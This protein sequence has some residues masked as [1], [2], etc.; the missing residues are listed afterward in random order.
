MD[1]WELEFK[2]SPKKPG[3]E[4]LITNLASLGFESF[5]ENN[6]SLMAYIT[7]ELF[8]KNNIEKEIEK[9]SFEGVTFSYEKN[10]IPSQNWNAEWEKDFDP[11]FVNDKL[12]I[13]APFH[14]LNKRFDYEVVIQPQMSFGTGH[15][16]T[17]RQLAS[18]LLELEL[19]NKNVLDVGTGTGVLAILAE[20]LGAKKI[21]GT[22]IDDGSYE[23][24]K[25]NV[26]LNGA[27]NIKLLKGDIDIV[28]EREF[29]VILANIN[30][31]VLI[32]HLPVYANLC[33][34]NGDLIMSGFFL[35]DVEELEKEALINGF[36]LEKTFNSDGWAVAYFTKNK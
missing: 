33:K 1:Y 8:I 24:A 25:S 20:K 9:L 18:F 27:E 28:T 7:S 3:E 31:N 15:H 17:T 16:D 11:V 21:I 34:L 10:L 6:D 36:H 26:E 2:V 5:M 22:E 14:N 23:N 30:K 32:K 13:K 19:K 29:D 12:V 4:I 35:S